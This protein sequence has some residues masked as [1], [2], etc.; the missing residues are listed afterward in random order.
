MAKSKGAKD[1]SKE[2]RE[3]PMPAILRNPHALDAKQRKAGP[4]R[5][6]VK[7]SDDSLAKLKQAEGEADALTLRCVQCQRTND[8][9]ADSVELAPCPYASELHGDE[10]EV[11]LCTDCYR[12][13]RDDI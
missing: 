1:K 12:I 11:A 8:D 6:D 2:T 5:E 3:A 7:V 13:R 9:G 4:H 10:R